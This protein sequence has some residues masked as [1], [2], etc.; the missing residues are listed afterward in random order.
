MN[1]I[2]DNLYIFSKLTTILALL[3]I[4]I[5]MSYVFIKSYSSQ[6][7]GSNALDERLNSVFN[8]IDN[9]SQNLIILKNKAI[10]LGIESRV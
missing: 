2:L 7:I 9:N 4:I 1:K 5:F 10:Q 6:N 3:S 8:S